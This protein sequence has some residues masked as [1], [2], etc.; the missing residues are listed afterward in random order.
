MTIEPFASTDALVLFARDF[1]EDRVGSFCSDLA[2][3]LTPDAAGHRAEFPALITCIGFVEFLSSLYAG[4]LE[5]N[6]LAKLQ[7]YAATFMD[8]ANYEITR[9]VPARPYCCLELAP[10]PT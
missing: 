2:I 7:K 6:G 10:K 1:F 4:S 8:K 5:G 9:V 3:C